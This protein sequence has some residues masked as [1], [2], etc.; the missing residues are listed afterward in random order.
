MRLNYKITH[1][2]E[3]IKLSKE[4]YNDIIAQVSW[5]KTP[6]FFTPG[7][8]GW[9]KLKQPI[10]IGEGVYVKAAKLKG[11]GVW[12]PD[13]RHAKKAEVVP[14]PP[15]DK[16]YLREAPHF[17]FDIDGKIKLIHSEDAPYGGICHHR[18]VQ[19]YENAQIL[20]KNNV[21]SILPYMVI[22]YP[23]LY[24]HNKKL[25]V[26]ISLSTSSEPYRFLQLG[27]N[28]KY[29]DAK[30][31]SFYE[32]IKEI[33]G[34]GSSLEKQEGKLELSKIIGQQF[35]RAVR[36]LTESGLFIHSG[37]WENIQFCFQR[38]NILLTDLDST[39]RI[40]IIPD[41]M[42]AIQGLR[43]F[44]SNLYRY[45]N[46]L[47]YPKAISVY[48]LDVLLQYDVILSLMKGYFYDLEEESLKEV[49]DKI[50]KYFAFYFYQF[51]R[52]GDRLMDMPKE[53]R[54][55]LKFEFDVFYLLCLNLLYPL[56]LK[57]NSNTINH[58]SLSTDELLTNTKEYLGSRFN[59]LSLYL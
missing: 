14:I 19:E 59:Y 21:Y 35:G 26:A 5:Q 11:V 50:W 6:S 29:V 37:G 36:G 8:T 54:K 23:D 43:D 46:K 48:Q 16:T 56:F 34:I 3:N 28:Y 31:Q 57:T 13:G 17:G 41:K 44:I 33:F 42:K 2:N 53:L 9:Y 10:N 30:L 22:E 55:S 45:V 24:F 7:R 52:L 58:L 27:W 25:G 4:D 51:R 15:T 47:Y 18:A 38:K 39:K 49:S 40:E 20:Q 12:N 1:I 32:E